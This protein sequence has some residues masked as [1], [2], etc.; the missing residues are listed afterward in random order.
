[1]R[2]KIDQAAPALCVWVLGVAILSSPALVAQTGSRTES[3]TAAPPQKNAPESNQTISREQAKE[4][5]RSVDEILN[6]VSTD[7]RLPIQHSVKRRLISRDEVNKFLKQKFDEDEGAK[8]LERSELV[9]KKFGLLD[10]DFNLRPFL[11]SLLTEQIAGFY[12]NKTK[13]VNLLDWIA[14]E[15]QKSVLAHELTHALQDQSV[16]LERWGDSAVHGISLTL[17]D[18][19]RHLE[20]D[21]LETAREAVAEGQAMVTFIDYSLRPSGR[22]LADSPELVDRFKDADASASGSPIL[23]RAP[24]L[25]QKSLLFP[26][27]EG[28][29]FEQA[30]LMKSGKQ[31]AFADVLAHPPSSSYEIMNPAAYLAHAPVP[32]L[33]LPDIH[34]MLDPDYAPY[35]VG[36]MGALDV[37]I[38]A[39]LFG[40]REMADALTPAWDGGLYFAAQRKSATA[41]EKSSTASLALFYLSR[42][43]NPDSAVS[44]AR[45]YAGQLAR[46][47]TRLKQNQADAK[48]GE[49]IYTTEEGD[50]LITRSGTEV[51]VSEGFPLALARRLCDTVQEA[52]SVGPTFSA[53]RLTQEPSLHL[54][55]FYSSFV[56]PGSLRLLPQDMLGR[57]APRSSGADRQREQQV[58]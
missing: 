42:W 33:R 37:Q 40:G 12:N 55:Q 50:V 58:W 19:N 15:E 38:L 56:R 17:K 6:F 30:V 46:K 5:F 24:L 52:Q 34:P 51:F 44:F 13:T 8:R 28:L 3:Q 45:T 16:D 53:S 1:M 29:G 54:A 4:L 22:T 32:L 18:D 48:D 26:Y 23:A 41:A 14:P 20:T 31:A 2:F 10:H 49:E 43:K 57:A 35:D 39:E 25:L 9:L 36:V 27:T 11:I 47:Y 7:T 21:E